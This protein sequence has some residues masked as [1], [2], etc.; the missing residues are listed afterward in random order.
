MVGKGEL[1]TDNRS[2]VK[3]GINQW[4]GLHHDEIDAETRASERTQEDEHLGILEG[5]RGRRI[6]GVPCTM[7]ERVDW[8]EIFRTQGGWYHSLHA[9]TVALAAYTLVSAILS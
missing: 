7:V 5:H 4:D 1:S 2:T 3:G 6:E 8:G 9:S